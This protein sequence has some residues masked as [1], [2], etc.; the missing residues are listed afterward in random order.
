MILP[1]LKLRSITLS[2]TLFIVGCDSNTRLEIVTEIRDST[3]GD[4]LMKRDLVTYSIAKPDERSYDFHS[5]VWQMKD[6]AVWKDKAVLTQA[7]FQKG[8]GHRRWISALHSFDASKGY[9]ILKVAEGDAPQNSSR[10]NYQ[11]SWR[12][13]DIAA[14]KEVRVIRVCT[15]PFEPF[16]LRGTP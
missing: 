3:S 13:W 2:I 1:R 7:D 5:L 10:V 6:A 11:Y 8:T 4:R 15:D 14:K 16:A 9:A 12:E